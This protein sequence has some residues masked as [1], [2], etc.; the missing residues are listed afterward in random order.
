M[1][2]RGNVVIEKKVKIESKWKMLFGMMIILG[3]W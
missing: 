3:V 2:L 1:K